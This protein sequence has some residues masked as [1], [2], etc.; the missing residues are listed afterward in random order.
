MGTTDHIAWISTWKVCIRMVKMISPLMN[1]GASIETKTNDLSS[2]DENYFAFLI[3][4]EKSLNKTNV[5]LL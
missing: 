3:K 1:Q 5:V 4:D 2:G